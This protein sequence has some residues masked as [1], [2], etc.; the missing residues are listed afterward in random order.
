MAKV[1][2]NAGIITGKPV[3]AAH[4]SQSVNA[5]T[6]AEA[7]DINISGSLT[8]NNIL[9]PIT[10]GVSGSVLTTNGAGVATFQQL[11]AVTASYV[12]SSGVDG[13]FGMDSIQSAS[14]AATASLAHFATEAST[15][16]FAINANTAI[17]ADTASIAYTASYITAS[18]VYG[19]YGSSSV[20][21]ASIAVT[22]SYISSSNV[23]GPL[24]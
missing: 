15:S 5:L 2:S 8:V 1:L 18:G 20:E 21:S 11:N 19:P 7:Y 13:P 4:V 23:F 12:S 16:I 22:A 9:Y 17:N 10:D 24:V 3:E 14:Y 6:A